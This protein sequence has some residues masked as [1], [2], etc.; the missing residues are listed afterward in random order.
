MKL[1]NITHNKQKHR[2]KKMEE[3]TR[4]LNELKK[5]LYHFKQIDL[6]WLIVCNSSHTLRFCY[7]FSVKNYLVFEAKAT[8][9][10]VNLSCGDNWARVDAG[11]YNSAESLYCMASDIISRF[12]TEH[13]ISIKG[14]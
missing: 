9:E 10:G 7:R 12:A 4:L 3:S 13:K 11:T 5:E 8:E 2:D 1:Y 6:R 14:V